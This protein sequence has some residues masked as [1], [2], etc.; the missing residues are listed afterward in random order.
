MSCVN[1]HPQARSRSQGSQ[2]RSGSPAAGCGDAALGEASCSG[3]GLLAATGSGRLLGW[4]CAG[5]EGFAGAGLVHRSLLFTAVC[6][7]LPQRSCC[8]S[9]V[10]RQKG[11]IHVMRDLQVVDWRWTAVS[12]AAW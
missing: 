10:E 9:M 2:E 7:G 8:L 6:W 12:R 1:K 5:S 4:A 11:E 3:P